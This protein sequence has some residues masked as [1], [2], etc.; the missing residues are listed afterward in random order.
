MQP[1]VHLYEKTRPYSVRDSLQTVPDRTHIGDFDA[2]PKIGKVS[3]LRR[4]TTV[5]ACHHHM[6][7]DRSR[8]E[9]G[10]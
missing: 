3:S 4:G 8:P 6:Y 5:K 10:G 9:V 2:A 1:S 7:L